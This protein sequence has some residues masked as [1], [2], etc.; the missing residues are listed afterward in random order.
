MMQS[1]TQHE[2]QHFLVFET[3]DSKLKRIVIPS[4]NQKINAN[5][6]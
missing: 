3:D 5:Q 2:K 1:R 4:V 6:H